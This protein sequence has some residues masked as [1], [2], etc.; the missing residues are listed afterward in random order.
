MKIMKRFTSQ[1]LSLALLK[2][3]FP[4]CSNRAK[5]AGDQLFSLWTTPSGLA[6][7]VSLF[8][9][10]VLRI[11]RHR[12]VRVLGVEL[13]IPRGVIGLFGERPLQIGVLE[14]EVI[15]VFLATEQGDHGVVVTRRI[16]DTSGDRCLRHGMRRLPLLPSVG[17]SSRKSSG[18]SCSSCSGT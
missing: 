15:S 1:T 2:M 4:I 13:H 7:Q 18:Q 6:D 5:S 16:T 9:S 14:L 3:S 10:P 12:L 17:C 11:N 8:A